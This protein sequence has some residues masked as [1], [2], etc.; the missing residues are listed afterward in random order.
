MARNTRNFS[1]NEESSLQETLKELK[2]RV[3]KLTKEN[4]IL[5]SENATLLEAWSKTEYFLS[6]VTDGV[7]LEQMMKYKTLPKKAV[8]KQTESNQIK[9]VDETEKAR[10]K[11]KKWR[12][13]NL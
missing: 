3:R 1:R 12:D 11:W 10:L 7:P 5:R 6:E 2:S 9:D 8:R 4:K 13:E